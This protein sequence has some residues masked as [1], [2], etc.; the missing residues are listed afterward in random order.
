MTPPP[1]DRPARPELRA[2]SLPDDDGGCAAA[3]VVAPAPTPKTPRRASGG[4]GGGARPSSGRRRRAGRRRGRGGRRRPARPAPAAALGRAPRVRA[5]GA[6]AFPGGDR[7]SLHPRRRPVPFRDRLLDPLRG[8]R[9]GRRGA[10]RRADLDRQ[11][12]RL[13][14]RHPVRIHP[15]PGDRARGSTPS[16]TSGRSGTAPA[17]PGGPATRSSPSAPTPRSRRCTASGCAWSRS[18]T[19]PAAASST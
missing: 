13:R 4:A 3:V 12:H 8:G 9:L 17:P 18:P 5:P 11:G 15:Q 7:L 16:S 1:D 2:V 19:I 10:P 14:H 6:A